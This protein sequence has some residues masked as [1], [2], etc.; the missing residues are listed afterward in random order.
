MLEQYSV[1]LFKMLKF[2]VVGGSGVVIDFLV[3]WICKEKLRIEKYF[4]N[5]IGFALASS[6]NYVLNRIW[7]F[8]SNNPEVAR[9]Y[10]TFMIISIVGLGINTL[11]LWLFISKFKTKF[12]VSKLFAIAITTIW[13]FLANL[14]ITF[15]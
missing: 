13:N 1:L 6:S 5:A 7:T 2:G 9:E 12:Y 4:S 14:L 8:Q 15:A 10:Y 3:T 11:F